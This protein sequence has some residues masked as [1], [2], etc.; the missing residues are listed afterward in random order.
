MFCS[1]YKWFIS[2]A[3]D[4]GKPISGLVRRHLRGCSA[5]R[6]FV[7]ASESIIQ[8]STQD[9]A[10]ILKGHDRAL[11]EKIISG[12]SKAPPSKR[13]SAR[14]PV[15]IPAVAA[16]SAV[17]II[18]IGIILF[19]S[20]QSSPLDPLQAIYGFDINQTSLEEKIVSIESP[21]E[22]EFQSLRQTLSSTATFLI[23]CLEQSTGEIPD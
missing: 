15:L 21:L 20:P 5:C 7:R 4:S 9:T 16:A 18:T 3:Q 19:T 14:K 11:D 12:L 17:I 23:S 13:P 2:H 6:E 1:L 10:A 22:E 8:K